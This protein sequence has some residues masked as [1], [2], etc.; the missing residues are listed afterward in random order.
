MHVPQLYSKDFLN[1]FL[2]F[3]QSNELASNKLTETNQ[4]KCTTQIEMLS[5]SLIN[6]SNRISGTIILDIFI[7]LPLQRS[8]LFRKVSVTPSWLQQG[9]SYVTLKATHLPID[10]KKCIQETD[11]LTSARLKNYKFLKK[12]RL[13][14]LGSH[15]FL[16]V[17]GVSGTIISLLRI[18]FVINYAH[19]CWCLLL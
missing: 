13:L 5:G 16:L 18:D 11:K 19:T 1:N 8:R 7:Q 2:L 9:S 12:Q 3:A 15:V 10:K 4:A 6:I 17:E 14:A